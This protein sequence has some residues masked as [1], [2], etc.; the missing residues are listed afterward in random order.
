MCYYAVIITKVI[1]ITNTFSLRFLLYFQLFS[2]NNCCTDAKK[3]IN[4]S[5]EYVC[6][7]MCLW[8]KHNKFANKETNG[9]RKK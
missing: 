5:H 7:Y 2:K 9:F 6:K 4:V 1:N 8:V 3:N